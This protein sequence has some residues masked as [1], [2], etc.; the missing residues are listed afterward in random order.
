MNTSYSSSLDNGIGIDRNECGYNAI[1]KYKVELND[2]GVNGEMIKWME[3]NC[4]DKYGWHFIPHD[5]QMPFPFG[6]EA[7][8]YKDQTAFV[9][10]ENKTDAIM[11]SLMWVDQS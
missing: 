1:F 4:N 2:Y 8:W 9:S 3:E 6:D 5:K 7:D 11:F 10:F